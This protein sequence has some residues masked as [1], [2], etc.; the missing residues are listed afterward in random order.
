LSIAIQAP[1]AAG[2]HTLVLRPCPRSGDSS[3]R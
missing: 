3:A 1:V 2:Y